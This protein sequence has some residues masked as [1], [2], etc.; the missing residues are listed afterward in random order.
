MPEDAIV[1]PSA[2]REAV[3]FDI[4]LDD[5]LVVLHL[6]IIDT[7]F[8]IGSGVYGAELG[9]EIPDKCRPVIHPVRY[10]FR[11]KD[12]QLNIFKSHPSEIG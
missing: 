1:P 5:V 4:V 7:V 11:I 12:R 8:S 2:D 6:Q 3:E 10:F 9:V